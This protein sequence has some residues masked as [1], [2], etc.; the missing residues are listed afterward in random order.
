MYQNKETM[1]T[2]AGI[3]GLHNM[4]KDIMNRLQHLSIP[5]GLYTTNNV[6]LYS[7]KDN[8]VLNISKIEK[9][10]NE[11]IISDD[12]FEGLL[13]ITI[14]HDKSKTRKNRKKDKKLK[15]DIKIKIK[16]FGNKKSTK[17]NKKRSNRNTKK[18]LKFRK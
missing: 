16:P 13:S 6:E 9:L 1:K 3:S 12:L 14:T 7:T 18:A 2:T 11:D 8:N 10:E 17:K 4:S 15:G 5:F